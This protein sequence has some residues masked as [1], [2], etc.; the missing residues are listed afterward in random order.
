MRTILRG[1]THPR[2]AQRLFIET[3]DRTSDAA[4]DVE[5]MLSIFTKNAA[6]RGLQARIPVPISTALQP[7][8][9]SRGLQLA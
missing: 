1:Q 7:Q 6:S 5:T 2:G 8:G 4:V 9:A 3:K